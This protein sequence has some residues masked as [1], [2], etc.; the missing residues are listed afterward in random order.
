[1]ELDLFPGHINTASK[2]LFKVIVLGYYHKNNLGDDLF[3]Q[4]FKNIFPEF[5]FTFVDILS[6]KDID[7]HDILFIG[8][9]SFLDT[10]PN[11]KPG[12][13]ITKPVYYI[14][15]GLETEIHPEHQKL[16]DSAVL[17]AAR[18][19]KENIKSILIKDIVHSLDLKKVNLKN[20][21]HQKYPESIVVCP[22]IEC[23][24]TYT[25]EHWVGTSWNHYKSELAQFIDNLI[26]E[27][28]EVLFCPFCTNTK[29]SD[30]WSIHEIMSLMKHRDESLISC[31]V[32][33]TFQ[34]SK[35]VITQRYHGIILADVLGVPCISIAHHSKLKYGQYL[36]YYSFEKNLLKEKFES[37]LGTKKKPVHFSFK[38]LRD[39]VI[40]SL[41]RNGEICSNKKLPYQ[42]NLFREI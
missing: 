1:M 30:I 3:M 19:P 39:C 41:D 22:S 26:D 7:T 11:I 32:L 18:T 25:S 2:K 36:S 5:E 31:N 12:V 27:N 35:F 24:P 29:R 4:A 21:E 33:E 8:G 15:V 16:M 28:H 37:L 34:H 13:K 10:P 42:C 6:Q 20:L 38:E 9:G 23:V 14:S 17:V 40:K